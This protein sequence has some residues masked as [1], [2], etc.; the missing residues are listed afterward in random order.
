MKNWEYSDFASVI[1]PEAMACC[2]SGFRVTRMREHNHV[3]FHVV[4]TNICAST[5]NPQ[6]YRTEDAAFRECVDRLQASLLRSETEMAADDAAAEAAGRA[7]RSG[8]DYAC[9][10]RD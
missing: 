6:G 1:T 3:L 8:Y 9:G 10:Y 2:T 5:W 7:Y 4:G